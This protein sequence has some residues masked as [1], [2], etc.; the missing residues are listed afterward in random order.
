[1]KQINWHFLI[2]SSKNF[3]A[4]LLKHWSTFFIAKFLNLTLRKLSFCSDYE[5]CFGNSFGLDA[6]SFALGV[7][8][9]R[10]GLQVRSKCPFSL[11][12]CSRCSPAADRGVMVQSKDFIFQLCSTGMARM[13]I[14]A[15][16]T[17]S[18][19][20]S[21]PQ[22]CTS[23]WWYNIRTR[24]ADAPL[25]P[26]TPNCLS[27]QMLFSTS[28]AGNHPMCFSPVWRQ[29]TE[30]GLLRW[31]VDPSLCSWPQVST[32]QPGD[33]GKDASGEGEKL[34]KCVKGLWTGD[35]L[36]KLHHVYGRNLKR[37]RSRDVHPALHRRNQHLWRQ[38]R[39]T[40]ERAVANLVWQ[41]GND[42]L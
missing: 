35:P 11:Q 1:M 37:N 6:W 20:K 33:G 9:F 27:V 12:V 14:P 31:S 4:A 8:W 10:E 40:E 24:C 23:N 16:Q 22:S 18:G 39:Q 25:C 17:K 13:F 42:P 7:F 15:H 26:R 21:I 29:V 34:W 36:Q 38:G 28:T 19:A 41:V 3:Q 2:K 5:W 30:S 32:S